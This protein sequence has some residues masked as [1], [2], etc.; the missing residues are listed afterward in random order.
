MTI[1]IVE[2]YHKLAL[3]DLSP[4]KEK[5]YIIKRGPITDD[6]KKV[7]VLLIRSK[8]KINLDLLHRTPDLKFILTATSGLNHIDL[9]ACKSRQ[10]KVLQPLEP[11]SISAA[12]H[13]IALIT[14]LSRGLHKAQKNTHENHWRENLNRG[15]DLNEKKVGLIGLGRVGL[16]VSQILNAFGCHVSAYDPYKNLS[17]FQKANVNK[18]E[19]L[20]LILKKSDILSL[21]TPLTEETQGLLNATNMRQLKSGVVLIN[22]SRGPCVEESALI[23]NLKNKSIRAAGLDVFS[24]EPL[25]P[26]NELFTLDNVLLTPHIGAFTEDAYLKSGQQVIKKLLEQL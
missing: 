9:E 11:N 23:T 18:V 10:V 17:Y 6:L 13:T 1:L 12:E 8:T 2:P 19:D 7:E 3:N 22:T 24:S 14:S 15:F 4:L 25:P 5:G 26:N 16:R 20:N 21:H